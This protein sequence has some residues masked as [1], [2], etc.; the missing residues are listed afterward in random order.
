M[1]MSH[2]E[3]DAKFRRER[4]ELERR[5]FSRKL[6]EIDDNIRRLD[7]TIKGLQESR[8]PSPIVGQ[9]QN[10]RDILIKRKVELTNGSQ[11]QDAVEAS[12]EDM[13][14]AYKK[15]EATSED[16]LKHESG[17]LKRPTFH[18]TY[19]Y[20]ELFHENIDGDM[21]L[22]FPQEVVDNLGLKEG[23]KV[24]LSASKNGGLVIKLL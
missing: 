12:R 11:L 20:E 9:L 14:E 4:D 18:Q 5:E 15:G 16:L 23:D 2:D 1:G 22:T 8:Q 19:K 7:A 24:G 3:I 6:R 13:V 21:I 10:E 17:Q